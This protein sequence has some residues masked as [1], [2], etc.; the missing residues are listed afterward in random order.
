ME[1]RWFFPENS[2]QL[3]NFV[4]RKFNLKPKP[5]VRT[6]IYYPIVNQDDLGLKLRAGNWEIKKRR[7]PGTPFTLSITRL[8][9]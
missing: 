1:I 4:Q 2:S 5:E 7:Q 9:T 6:D 8:A 3:Q